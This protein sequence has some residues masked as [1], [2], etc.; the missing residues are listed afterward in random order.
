MRTMKQPKPKSPQGASNPAA[1]PQPKP[2][3]EARRRLLNAKPQGRPRQQ[4]EN[5]RRPRKGA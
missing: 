5:T 4:D 1:A 2:L 3:D